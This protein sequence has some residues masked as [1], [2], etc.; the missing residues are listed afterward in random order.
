MDSVIDAKNLN[1]LKEIASFL[2]ETADKMHNFGKSLAKAIEKIEKSETQKSEEKPIK[3]EEKTTS[4]VGIPKKIELKKP[5]PPKPKKLA[6][7]ETLKEQEL[8]P[9]QKEEGLDIIKNQVPGLLNDL[10]KIME[11]EDSL[12]MTLLQRNKA[13]KD[14]KQAIEILTKEYEK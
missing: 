13:L 3:I 12:K 10:R 2:K 11:E 14:M 4:K 9:P 1:I 7:L 6:Q 5:I 8:S